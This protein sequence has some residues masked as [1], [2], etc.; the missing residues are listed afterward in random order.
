MAGNNTNWREQAAC[1]GKPTDYFFPEN[2]ATDKKTDHYLYGR[3]ICRHCPVKADCLDYA[4]RC[5]QDE[6][7][8]YGLWGGLT[9][10]ERWLYDPNWRLGVKHK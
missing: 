2:E 3:V 1:L 4:M 10:H 9:P 5:E 7:W 8:R 6:R